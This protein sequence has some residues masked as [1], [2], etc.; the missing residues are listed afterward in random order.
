M[1]SK[2]YIFPE[3]SLIQIYKRNLDIQFVECTLEFPDAIIP[4]DPEI[5]VYQKVGS[6]RNKSYL[7]RVFVNIQKRPKVI[8]TVYKTSKIEKY[9]NKV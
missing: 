5:T 7:Y 1:R 4:D 8:V 6:E 3:H 2:H 9:E